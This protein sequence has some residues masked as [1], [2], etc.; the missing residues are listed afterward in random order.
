L[1]HYNL[2]VNPRNRQLLDALTLMSAKGQVVNKV[3]ESIRRIVD[4]NPF[5]KL[6][7]QYPGITRPG[8]FG[9]ETPK[10][11][12]EHHVDTTPGAP[13]R[14]KT[15]ILVPVRYKAAKDETEFML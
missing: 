2:L 6:L 1:S 11:Q 9:K 10:H 8:V 3:I 5:N 14:S 13:V 4:D 15:R 7:P 12:V